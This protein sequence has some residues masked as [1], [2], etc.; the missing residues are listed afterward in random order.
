LVKETGGPEKNTKLSQVT[1]KCF[2]TMF[3]RVHLALSGILTIYLYVPEYTN[4]TEIQSVLRMACT[5]SSLKSA[6]RA[7]GMCCNQCR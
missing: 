4:V 1:D 3:Y 2:H 5:K 6:G 7:V